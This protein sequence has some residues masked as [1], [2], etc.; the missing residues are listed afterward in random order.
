MKDEAT[1]DRF[2]A[3]SEHRRSINAHSTNP[4][5]LADHESKVEGEKPLHSSA[6]TPK[7]DIDLSAYNVS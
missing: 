6:F 7:A 1:A 5:R 3:N 4:V 2:S